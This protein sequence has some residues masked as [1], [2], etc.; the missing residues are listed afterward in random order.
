MESKDW[1]W[2]GRLTYLHSFHAGEEVMTRF[3]ESL[4]CCGDRD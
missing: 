4:R 1:G 3:W 2:M